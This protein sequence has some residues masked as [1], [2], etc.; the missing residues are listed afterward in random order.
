MIKFGKLSFN[1]VLQGTYS[2][3]KQPSWEGKHSRS[4]LTNNSV[5]FLKQ[6]DIILTDDAW[7]VTAELEVNSYEEA[8]LTIRND[9]RVIYE[10][11]RE[12][13]SIAELRQ[14]EVLLDT[15]ETRIQ[16]FRHL[17]PKPDNRRG[18]MNIGARQ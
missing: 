1:F 6:E 17:L 8:V 4:N 3:R 7:H 16:N 10:S 12:F 9:L 15:L 18:L 14:I 13:T 2:A 5:M 11:K